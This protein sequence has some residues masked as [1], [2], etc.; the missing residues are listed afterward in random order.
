M[1]SR[2]LQSSCD[3]SAV[4]KVSNNLRVD[5]ELTNEL[6]ELLDRQRNEALE[7]LFPPGASLENILTRLL[8]TDS[9]VSSTSTCAA[10]NQ[11]QRQISAIGYRCIGFGQCGLVFERPG[12]AYVVKLAK[13]AYKEGLWSDFQAHLNVRQAFCRESNPECRVP[14]LFSFAPDSSI[15]WWNENIQFFPDISD[16]VPL[17]T[18]ALITER[19]LPLPKVVRQALIHQYCPPHLQTAASA[20]PTNRDCLAR[21]YLGSRRARPE[22]LSPNFTL[23]NFNLHLDQ[24]LELNLPVFLYAA[25]MGE[26]MAIIHWAAHVDG[27]DIEFVLGS[28]ANAGTSYNK[29][30]FLNLDLATEQASCMSSIKDLDAAMRA[31]FKRRTTSM[32]VLDFNLCHIWREDCAW[33]NPDGLISHLVY[34]F[35]QNDP[36]YP[37]PADQDLWQ[38]FSAA[39]RLKADQILAVPETDQRLVCLPGR[40]LDACISHEQGSLLT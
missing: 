34:S 11:S 27:F 38:K 26:A 15:E 25:A 18:M 31:N 36:Y 16:L 14:Q 17:P 20:N 40:F 3:D 22:L 6:S 2:R 8:S 24:M 4:F 35:F 13:P 28:D 33:E 32:W 9:M 29:D 39:Y 7:T 5:I 30:I 19:I 10:F 1:A 23:R 37:R 12:R 21:L